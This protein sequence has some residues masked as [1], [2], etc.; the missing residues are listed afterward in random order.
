MRMVVGNLCVRP[1]FARMGVR[2]N[3]YPAARVAMNVDVNLLPDQAVEDVGPQQDQHYSHGEFQRLGQRR[4][5]RILQNQG[6]AREDAKRQHV[7]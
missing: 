7:P 1:M 3:M 6:G 5:D 2:V 4:A